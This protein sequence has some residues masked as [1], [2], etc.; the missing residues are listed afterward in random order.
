M[1]PAYGGDRFSAIAPLSVCNILCV[2]SGRR[3]SGNAN[4]TNLSESAINIARINDPSGDKKSNKSFTSLSLP[5][6]NAAFIHPSLDD[7]SNENNRH[8]IG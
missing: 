8:K 1:Q 6:V 2:R 3:S 7:P 4:C 5:V